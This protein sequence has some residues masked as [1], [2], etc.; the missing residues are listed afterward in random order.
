MGGRVARAGRCIALMSLLLLQQYT[1][2]H[3]EAL[4]LFHSG[5]DPADVG[6]PVVYYRHIG[7]ARAEQI[8]RFRPLEG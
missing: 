7:Q 1:G 5:Q 2:G 4:K 8:A 6:R 3:A